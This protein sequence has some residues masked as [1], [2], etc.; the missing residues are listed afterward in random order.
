M[1]ALRRARR[2]RMSATLAEGAVE[3]AVVEEEVK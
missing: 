3:A 2:R 1:R